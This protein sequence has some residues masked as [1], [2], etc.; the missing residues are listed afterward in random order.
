ME[1]LHWRALENTE[2]IV[3]YQGFQFQI[4][5]LLWDFGHSKLLCLWSLSPQK[6]KND[7]NHWRLLWGWTQ[8]VP[9]TSSRVPLYTTAINACW[10]PLALVPLLFAWTDTPIRGFSEHLHELW[11]WLYVK[12]LLFLLHVQISIIIWFKFTWWVPTTLGIQ[13]SKVIECQVL[14]LHCNHMPQE[15]V[16]II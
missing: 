12:Q 14:T 5:S 11:G 2:V 16:F 13:I 4:C 7:V 3:R 6:Q 15:N 8:N 10:L 1:E 9:E